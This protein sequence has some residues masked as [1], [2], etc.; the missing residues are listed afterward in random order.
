MQTE[1]IVALDAQA[2]GAA[3]EV[4]MPLATIAVI[5]GELQHDTRRNSALASYG[6]DLV[7]IE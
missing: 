2:A 5:A 4:G 1:R 3:Y 6:A 7:I